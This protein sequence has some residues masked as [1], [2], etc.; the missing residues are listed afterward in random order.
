MSSTY[1]RRLQ[2]TLSCRW[3]NFAKA[4][5]HD[6]QCQVRNLNLKDAETQTKISVT[7]LPPADSV[8]AAFLTA[9]KLPEVFAIEMCDLVNLCPL[10]VLPNLRNSTV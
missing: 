7:L 10:T 8:S 3:G 2:N 6:F 1:G 5:A 9:P 4:T